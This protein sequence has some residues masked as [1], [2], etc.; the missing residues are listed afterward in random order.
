MCQPNRVGTSS[1]L[2]TQFKFK[3]KVKN[4]IN[5]NNQGLRCALLH[6]SDDRISLLNSDSKRMELEEMFEIKS[7]G[8]KKKH[9]EKSLKQ[10]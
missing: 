5:N 8:H 1:S 7:N 10:A 3:C 4:Q 2:T 9:D 6:N